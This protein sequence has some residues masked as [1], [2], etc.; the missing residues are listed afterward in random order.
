VVGVHKMRASICPW[1]FR[2]LGVDLAGG[3]SHVIVVYH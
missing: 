1:L 2:S 3:K